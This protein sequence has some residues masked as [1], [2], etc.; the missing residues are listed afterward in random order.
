MLHFA[1]NR[2]N[3]TYWS[4]DSMDYQRN[5]P[6]DLIELLRLQ[7]PRSGDV[8]LMHDDSDCSTHVLQT[9]LPEWRASGLQFPALPA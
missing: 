9:L 7:P 6:A 8:V 2:R 4:Y 1:W 3:L 5:A